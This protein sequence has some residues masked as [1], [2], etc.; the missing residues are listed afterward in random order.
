MIVFNSVV[1]YGNSFS[2]KVVVHSKMLGLLDI[3][4]R[5]GGKAWEGLSWSSVGLGKILEIVISPGLI[6]KLGLK[7]R[8]SGHF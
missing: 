3:K 2:V 6:S 4:H 5:P 8:A 1:E 7:S